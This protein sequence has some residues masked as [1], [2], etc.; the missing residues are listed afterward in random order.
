M[1]SLLIDGIITADF[2]NNYT[3]IIG[4]GIAYHLSLNL[5]VLTKFSYFFT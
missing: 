3:A 1:D 2:Q 5:E 4:S